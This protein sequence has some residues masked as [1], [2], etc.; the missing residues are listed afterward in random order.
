M[1][2][3]GYYNGMQ[4]RRSPVANTALAVSF[5]AVAQAGGIAA[6]AGGVAVGSGPDPPYA[7]VGIDGAPLEVDGQVDPGLVG[8]LADEDL[9]FGG[10]GPVATQQHGQHEARE[11][12]HDHRDPRGGELR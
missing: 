6:G 1:L 9:G 5:T 10:L 7:G 2:G 3:M 4:E 12:H 11:H 8:K